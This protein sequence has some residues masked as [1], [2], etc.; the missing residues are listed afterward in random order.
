[1]NIQHFVIHARTCSTFF[2]FWVFVYTVL[3]KAMAQLINRKNSRKSDM[4]YRS[5]ICVLV[6]PTRS[7]S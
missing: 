1:M 2:L 6:S 7:W 4:I 3:S 5:L